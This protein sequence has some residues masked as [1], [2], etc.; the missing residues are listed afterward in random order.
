MSRPGR[1]AALVLGVA[2]ATLGLWF[3]ADAGTGKSRATPAAEQAAP[4]LADSDLTAQADSDQAD[5]ARIFLSEADAERAYRQGLLPAGVHSILNLDRTMRHGEFH[6]NDDG[7][8]PGELSIRVDIRRQLVSV[9]RAGHEIGAAVVLYGADGKETPLGR[10]PVLRKS[11]D[12][13]SRAYDAPMP[14]SLWMTND[15]VALHGS[16]VDQGRATNG[17]VGVPL[18]FARL[19]FGAAE[20]GDVVEVVRSP[21]ENAGAKTA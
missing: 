11:E 21:P 12:Y 3:I 8:P 2:L 6:W 15:G 14:Y 9:F 19:L 5:A 16:S 20:V 18:G 13:R 10:F 1:W 4:S 7:V 17:C